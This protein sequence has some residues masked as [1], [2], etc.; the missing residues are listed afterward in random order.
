MS[1][2]FIAVAGVCGAL[3]WSLSGDENHTVFNNTNFSASSSMPTTNARDIAMPTYYSSSVKAKSKVNGGSESSLENEQAQTWDEPAIAQLREARLHGDDRA[4]PIVRNEAPHETPTPEELASPELYN[5]YETRQEM[6]LKAAYID[7]AH[8]EMQHIQEQ[9]QAMRDA[10]LDHVAMQEAEEKLT[11]LQAMT[12][13]LQEQHPELTTP[14]KENTSVN[15][16][17]LY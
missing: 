9:L 2:I 1:L 5:N 8:P 11:K 17:N 13:H 12:Q 6:K 14:A 4:P 16:R 3:W 15:R 7:A 10:G